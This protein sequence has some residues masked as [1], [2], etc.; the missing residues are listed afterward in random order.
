MAEIENDIIGRA[1][2]YTRIEPELPIA[3][4]DE[5]S[6]EQLIE[7]VSIL[8]SI[9][10]SKN[11]DILLEAQNINLP[12]EGSE[13]TVSFRTECNTTKYYQG[14]EDTIFRQVH[15]VIILL[16]TAQWF[17]N[18]ANI[19][20]YTG[21]LSQYGNSEKAI[22]DY[23]KKWSDGKLVDGK[24]L[25]DPSLSDHLPE[26]QTLLFQVIATVEDK[27]GEKIEVAEEVEPEAKD[28]EEKPE[29][30]DDTEFSSAKVVKKEPAKDQDGGGDPT[31]TP[32]QP[33]NTVTTTGLTVDQINQKT[34]YETQWLYNFTLHQIAVQLGIPL[35]QIPEAQRGQI[36]AE[37]QKYLRDPKN[38]AKLYDLKN[39]DINR[40]N[41]FKELIKNIRVITVPVGEAVV[42]LDLNASVNIK[43]SEA[44]PDV[45]RIVLGKQ[46]V[47]EL[48]AILPEYIV[49]NINQQLELAIALS[50]ASSTQD[51]TMDQILNVVQSELDKANIKLTTEQKTLLRLLLKSYIRARAGEKALNSKNDTTN[52]GAIAADGA[53]PY[54]IITRKISQTSGH[55]IVQTALTDKNDNLEKVNPFAKDE[56]SAA[57][58]LSANAYTRYKKLYGWWY[59][60]DPKVQALI[61]LD[62]QA[63]DPT[64]KG[65]KE[66]NGLNYYL[67]WNIQTFNLSTLPDLVNR[68]KL[69]NLLNQEAY[70]SAVNGAEEADKQ[71]LIYLLQE[72]LTI[73]YTASLTPEYKA[74]LLAYTKQM[75]EA[76]LK[77][78]LVFL[79]AMAQNE[80]LFQE[81]ITAYNE[82]LAL[83]QQA[84][85]EDF[86]YANI[87]AADIQAYAQYEANKQQFLN[88]YAPEAAAEAK[89]GFGRISPSPKVASP[90][91]R[92]AAALKSTADKVKRGMDFGKALLTAGTGAGFAQAYASN[93]DFRTLVNVG[94]GG[95]IGVAIAT[96][97][98]M[99][100]QTA[101]FVGGVGGGI[102]GGIAG[103]ALA[104]SIFGPV[105]T[106][107]GAV[108]G[109]VGGAA[110][111]AYGAPVVMGL[112]QPA[113]VSSSV[114]PQAASFGSVAESLGSTVTG[115]STAA[116]TGV[117][118]GVAATTAG[119]AGKAFGAV[120]KS[121]STLANP[122]ILV[123]M[124]S[125]TSVAGI[126][127]YTLFVIQW[128]FLAPLPFG[129]PITSQPSFS[130]YVEVTKTGVPA[131]FEN[132]EEGQS[133]T[134]T[135]T[136][137]IAP[138]SQYQIEV[139]EMSDTFSFL[140][141][142][143]VF[144]KPV[145]EPLGD[146]NSHAVSLADFGLTEGQK[147]L[148]PASAQYEVTMTN[149]TAGLAKD[150]LI[151]NLFKL[152]FK[153][154]DAQGTLLKTE[155][156][157][158]RGRVT[159]GNPKLDGCWPTDGTLTQLPYDR[160]NWNLPPQ[161]GT[162]SHST[163]QF[164]SDA[165]DIANP[166]GTPVFAP[167]DGIASAEVE[168]NSGGQ[169]SGFGY[170]VSLQTPNGEQFIF[171]HLITKPFN[172]TKEVKAGDPIGNMG[173]S[174]NSTGSHTHY[175]L[176]SA[177]NSPPGQLVNYVPDYNPPLNKY[178]ETCY[179]VRQ[180][181]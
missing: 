16:G 78:E 55:D 34:R 62:L 136:I 124:L 6:E 50:G 38:L 32:L 70:Q 135:Y 154:Y 118:A 177:V 116:A 73:G 134:V 94:T 163:A 130:E 99:L 58:G 159:I 164:G 8:A 117:G 2:G 126:T 110:I 88:T 81:Q 14:Q 125:L 143:G 96:I 37:V 9:F 59:G 89:K 30:D 60:L 127:L 65:I 48:N 149:G 39:A 179:D 146:G 13:E 61:I 45:L 109:G 90:A 91:Q 56:K 141:E 87:V 35:E 47:E 3:L 40:L 76:E 169:L 86:A 147:L 1:N 23:L 181:S 26:I 155:S 158:A 111:G 57:G 24:Y 142:N 19:Q 168:T 10:T 123:P 180:G 132:F 172:G 103:G 100:S 15:F 114:A 173:S 112:G 84:E 51:M 102:L 122:A 165:F 43:S 156:V 161:Y 145:V 160:A 44:L 72:D 20:G 150:T 80:A 129:S 108:V 27:F 11:G 7:V 95:L 25:Y 85:L 137:T 167:F 68:S 22:R 4:S 93:K 53:K 69:G 18:P 113:A 178:V 174:G 131:R 133:E 33:D 77:E 63:K 21:V 29:E 67:P 153:A 152:R 98:K 171:A 138:K 121:A 92:Q 41:A 162:G 83:I 157:D 119:A 28:V 42:A 97:M 128:S 144:I 151:N 120:A 106:V 176:F 71:R 105:G 82:Q 170:F 166:A 74:A 104:G 31:F 17:N 101:S 12:V 175:E 140:G 79:Q 107:I 46:T 66:S 49:K 5:L 148:T 139:V 64:F 36:L 54:E 75:R 52:T 115:G